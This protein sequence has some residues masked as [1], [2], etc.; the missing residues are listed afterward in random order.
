M[1]FSPCGQSRCSRR[2][3]L[4]VRSDGRALGA[5]VGHR[6]ES[7]GWC[8][9]VFDSGLDQCL[10]RSQESL[11]ILLVRTC[12]RRLDLEGFECRLKCR[13]AILSL[14]RWTSRQGHWGSVPIKVL[15]RAPRFTIC[16]SGSGRVNRDRSWCVVSCAPSTVQ[17][18]NGISLCLM[19][20]ELIGL[21]TVFRRR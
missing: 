3:L 16:R 7:D 19:R 1:V 14:S 6:L 2:L 8:G 13:R 17:F 5:Y 11:I 10:C 20:G 9:E 18:R 12:L 21:S 15:V 4:L